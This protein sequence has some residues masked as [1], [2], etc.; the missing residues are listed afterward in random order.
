MREV[1]RGEGFRCPRIGRSRGRD[2]LVDLAT[3]ALLPPTPLY[4]NAYAA[5]FPYDRAAPVPLIW[6]RFLRQ[7][8]LRDR[9][10]RATLAM[11]FGYIISR[12]VDLQKI[13]AIIGPTRGGKGIIADI[14]S[15]LLGGDVAAPTLADMAGDFGLEELTDKAL[16]IVTDARLPMRARPP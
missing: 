8:F 1:A 13:L 5:A 3:G 4:F 11:W 7:L 15:E 2:G 14:L 16:A 9:E 6:R 10:A 12:R